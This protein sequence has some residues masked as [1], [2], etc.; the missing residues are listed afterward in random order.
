MVEEVICC[1]FVGADEFDDFAMLSIEA[2]FEFI[3]TV[4]FAVLRQAGDAV[5]IVAFEFVGCGVFDDIPLDGVLGVV[6][7]H[8]LLVAAGEKIDYLVAV[9]HEHSS[10]ERS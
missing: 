8:V 3:D 7:F 1:Q 6:F 9:E 10:G 4:E 5:E 2:F